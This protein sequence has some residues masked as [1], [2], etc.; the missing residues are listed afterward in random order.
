M[1]ATTQVQTKGHGRGRQRRQP[2]RGGLRQVQRDH[3]VLAELLGDQVT[4]GD[5]VLG[6]FQPDQQAVGL[7]FHRLDVDVRLGQ[8]LFEALLSGFGEAQLATITADLDRWVFGKQIGKGVD[9]ADKKY[10][11]D[12]QVLP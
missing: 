3:I 4:G 9:E 6:V 1:H 7:L 5:L 10:H 12:Q 11:Q 8:G 2:L